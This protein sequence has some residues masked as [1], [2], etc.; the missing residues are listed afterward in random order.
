MNTT[1]NIL[2]TFAKE[3]RS[4]FPAIKGQVSVGR[5]RVILATKATICPMSEEGARVQSLWALN[6]TLRISKSQIESNREVVMSDIAQWVT[7]EAKI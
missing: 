3:I 2:E 7:R 1:A 4:A 5:G 6:Q